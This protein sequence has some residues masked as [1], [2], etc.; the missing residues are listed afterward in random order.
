[1]KLR[2]KF[3]YCFLAA[4]F[5]VAC[6][7]PKQVLL[8]P[9]EIRA[10]APGTP[11][12]YQGSYPKITDI[13]H[14]K[15]DVSFNWDSAFV[16]GKAYILAKP[17]FYPEN[18]AIFNANGFKI[19]EVSLINKEHRQLL[20]YTYDGKLLTIQ[21]DKEYSRD[22][23]FN[24][25]IDYIAMPNKLT[26]GKDI[27]S[28]DD[29]G[30][31]FINANGKEKNKPTQLWSQGE[32][33][34]NS[35]W[36]PTINGPQE[37]MTQEISLTVPDSMVTLSNG[38]LTFSKN[39]VNGT[40]TDTWKQDK[41]S[42]TYLT[43]IA[44]GNFVITKDKWRDKEVSYYMEPK[45]APNARMIFGNT[46]EMIEFFSKK[47]GIDFQWDKYSQIVVRD[48]VSGAM[49][50]TTATV[51]YDRMN[52]TESQYMDESHEDIISHELFHHWFG[53]LVTCES[54]ANIPLNESFAT[55][56]EYLWN[57]Y[58]YGRDYA[59]YYE[60]EDMTAYMASGKSKKENVI[61][62]DYTDREQ[63]FDEASYQ[64]G[65][66][67]LHM[68]RKTVGDDAFFKSLTLYLSKNA[69]KTAEIHDLRLAF[70]EVTGQDMNWF[71]NQW[72]LASGHPVLNIQTSYD[73]GS[74]NATVNIKQMQDQSAVPLYRI[75][76]A[77]DIYAGGNVKR[78]EIVL[79]KQDQTFTF[80]V[81]S[82]PQLIN[83]DAE[84]YILAQKV[85]TKTLQQYIFQY[86]N[87][88]LFMD[89]FEAINALKS[90][91]NDKSAREEIM[92]ALK[93]KNWYIRK[94]V[95]EFVPKL[96][97]E[98]QQSV[99]QRVKELALNDTRSY[100]RAEALAALGRVYG[101]SNNREI[102]NQAS[103]DKALSVIKALEEI[104]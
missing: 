3:C 39:N 25:F 19:N 28:N 34:C 16:Y 21:L 68:L 32:T 5:L 81:T 70:E 50:N 13:I 82:E 35:N 61:R 59:D 78:E 101:R 27:A 51:L 85:E 7:T 38:L 37:K 55:Y 87:A 41:P 95:L 97:K 9:V 92:K 23:E 1:M 42:S 12:I 65:G 10:N 91:Q 86:E 84:K 77:I 46:P 54:W 29:R 63:M 11:A 45:Y 73:A 69:Y 83:V 44:A 57:E 67:I 40:H 52:M 26:V 20:K 104:R 93:D 36:F 102:F 53:D 48:F 18:K 66:L 71:F 49:E 90:L 43:M 58:K 94:T 14:T 103:K 31:Y 17:Y 8:A 98:E 64:K 96:T 60:M 15:L 22:E 80:P 47:L 24:L 75:P 99:Y 2:T 4:F 76:M 30:F 6:S 62:F 74:G 72:F 89:R 79:D 100:V 33:E 88:P 56:G